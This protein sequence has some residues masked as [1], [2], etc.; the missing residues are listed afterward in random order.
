[1]NNEV[2]LKQKNL[3]GKGFFNCDKILEFGK[4][5][6]LRQ[7]PIIGIN[8]LNWDNVHKLGYCALLKQKKYLIRSLNK[9]K[10]SS[11]G[12]HFFY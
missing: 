11:I 6:E 9:K 2:I 10:C 7:C 5:L 1:M 3:I 8:F 4:D 12:T